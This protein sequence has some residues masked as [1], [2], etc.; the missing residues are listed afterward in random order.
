M[1]ADSRRAVERH[2]STWTRLVER[3]NTINTQ[4]LRTP[5]PRNQHRARQHVL[6]CSSYTYTQNCQHI[7]PQHV[8]LTQSGTVHTPT[9]YRQQQTQRRESWRDTR[10]HLHSVTEALHV[11]CNPP[12]HLALTHSAQ[13]CPSA[14]SVTT[15]AHS[16]SIRATASP[17]TQGTDPV[18][19]H[20]GRWGLGREDGRREAWAHPLPELLCT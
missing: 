14:H 6:H 12:W 20:P 15:P 19:A 13:R 1:T 11:H 18:T 9:V 4:L 3:V 2:P 16:S 17:S 5:T 7:Q 8:T 10:V